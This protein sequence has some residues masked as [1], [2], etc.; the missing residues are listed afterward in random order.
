MCVCLPLLM[1]G[2]AD[3][4]TGWYDG[5]VWVKTPELLARDRLLASYRVRG[6]G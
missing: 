6:R 3:E 4:E 1:D 5:Q 2:M